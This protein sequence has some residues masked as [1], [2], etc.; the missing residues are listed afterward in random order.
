MTHITIP[1]RISHTVTTDTTVKTVANVTTVTTVSQVG[2]KVGFDY[3][4][5]L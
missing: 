4:S 1:T 5:I 2:R 3:L